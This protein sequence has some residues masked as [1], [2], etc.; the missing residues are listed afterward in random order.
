MSKNTYFYMA[1]IAVI[2]LVLYF[3]ISGTSP[4][5]TIN[6]NPDITNTPN[7]DLKTITNTTLIH[8]E[9]LTPTSTKNS[10]DKIIKPAINLI[11]IQTTPTPTPTDIVNKNTAFF[12]FTRGQI[13]SDADIT[14][15]IKLYHQQDSSD[16]PEIGHTE[17]AYKWSERGLT[18]N[19][20]DNTEIH[21]FTI[22]NNIKDDQLLFD[23]ISNEYI[24]FK[25]IFP[26]RVIEEYSIHDPYINNTPSFNFNDNNL[27]KCI[28]KKLK[29]DKSTI[30][31][32]DQMLSLHTLNCSKISDLSG[33]ESWKHLIKL[34]ISGTDNLDISPL[35]KVENLGHLRL[36][37]EFNFDA[38]VFLKHKSLKFLS[39]HNN[40]T[41]NLNALVSIPNLRHLEL[42]NNQISNLD[43]VKNFK[44]L[45][46][47]TI[48][49]NPID[50]KKS[51]T[52]SNSIRFL[53][54]NNVPSLSFELVT[55]PT[56][57]NKFKATHNN[58]SNIDWFPKL[59]H[60]SS[61]NLNNNQLSG[62]S[63]IFKNTNI[64]LLNLNNNQIRHLTGIGQL[65][66]LKRL[67]ITKNSLDCDSLQL[68]PHINIS[69]SKN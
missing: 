25:L 50:S 47:L 67:N 4:K 33:I 27:K 40:K 35:S 3:I 17:L 15:I 63:S 21:S 45:E 39:V 11:K 69:C 14:H 49:N 31:S 26:W 37:G 23:S 36:R 65:S 42:N 60:L 41:T 59:N 16:I 61:V 13:L 12:G 30:P 57:L 53:E 9:N 68:E 64:K 48:K 58:L 43:F 34:S 29:I 56:Y 55:W 52:F 62:V 2:F 28:R 24:E 10:Q 6:N 54:L 5:Q 18:I 46:T 8:K 1:F 20:I 66:N 44:R 19:I 32:R 7:S 38:N 51:I 22:V